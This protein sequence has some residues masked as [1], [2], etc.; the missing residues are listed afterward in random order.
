VGAD[1]LDR[2]VV[3]DL[4]CENER[5]E[6]F[7]VELQKA[8]QSFFKD[9]MLYYSTFSIQEQGQKGA[10][11]YQL[12]TVY[13]VAI[14]DFVIDEDNQDKIVVSKK[15]HGR[16]PVQGVLR[17]THFCDPANAQFH[18]RRAGIGNQF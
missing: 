6:K 8:K 16:G 10:W 2:K 1:D 9:R 15:T 7:T 11:D 5:G 4:Y 18:Q 14:L 13:V 17:K 3:F 12:K